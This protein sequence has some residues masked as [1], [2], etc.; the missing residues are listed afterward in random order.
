MLKIR[1]LARK[2]DVEALMKLA[3]ECHESDDFYLRGIGYGIRFA[4]K[5]LTKGEKI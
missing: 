3:E 5:I 2:D 4:L 1:L